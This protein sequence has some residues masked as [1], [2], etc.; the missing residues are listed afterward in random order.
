[1]LKLKLMVTECNQHLFLWNV[2][3]TFTQHF[4]V[5]NVIN[6][7]TQHFFTTNAM[8]VSVQSLTQ[9]MPS[10]LIKAMFAELSYCPL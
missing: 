7:F 3:N 8:D 9:H 10:V 2:I 5:W 6:T 1:M 4:F